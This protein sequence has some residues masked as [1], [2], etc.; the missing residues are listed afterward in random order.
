[1]N[2]KI[3]HATEIIEVK[4]RKFHIIPTRP[5]EKD[6]SWTFIEEI[7]GELVKPRDIMR[8]YTPKHFVAHHIRSSLG[9]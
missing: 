8:C 1:M 5:N 9:A 6:T 4:G 7:D 3:V 2:M